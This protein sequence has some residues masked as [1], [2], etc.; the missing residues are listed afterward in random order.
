MR[1]PGRADPHARKHP[2]AAPP[3]SQRAPDAPWERQLALAPESIPIRYIAP[4]PF[5]MS[6][7][8]DR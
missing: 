7:A 2:S 8:C 3:S 6:I 4:F 5:M 1:P